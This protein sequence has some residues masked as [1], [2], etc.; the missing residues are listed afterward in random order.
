VK[1]G[2]LRSEKML[3]L[4]PIIEHESNTLPYYNFFLII[5]IQSYFLS[6]KHISNTVKNI[7][8]VVTITIYWLY[9]TKITYSTSLRPGMNPFFPL[10]LL[11]VVKTRKITKDNFFSIRHIQF[12]KIILQCSFWY[13]AKHESI[14]VSVVRI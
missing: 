5:S 4:Q 10:I 9:T 11:L 1:L 14:Q 13:T 6:F 7:K 12:Q 2:I 3:K 8:L